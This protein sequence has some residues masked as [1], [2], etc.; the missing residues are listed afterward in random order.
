MPD[1]F[2]KKLPYFAYGLFKPGQLAYHQIK[3]YVDKVKSKPDEITGTLM[4]RDGIPVFVPGESYIAIGHLIHFKP[5]MQHDAY[6]TIDKFEPK[7]IYEWAECTTAG[8]VK[9]N[10]LCGIAPYNGCHSIES[11]VWDGKNDPLFTDGIDEVEQI[12][13]N[14]NRPEGPYNYKPVFRLQM[15]YVLLWTA[16]ERYVTLRYGVNRTD[17]H[18]RPLSIRQ[19]LMDLASE[20]SFVKSIRKNINVEDY[21]IIYRST[22]TDEKF[23]IKPNNPRKTIDYYY[24]VRSNAVHRGKALFYDFNLLQISTRDLLAVFEDVLA[25]AFQ[26]ESQP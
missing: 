17:E 14:T 22:G 24:L 26:E 15:A 12:L 11:A 8:G 5:D 4:E 13:K 16:I 19:N 7:K 23:K 3:K 9:A 25:G 6:E 18:G 10:V 1:G 20:E 2:N 21:R